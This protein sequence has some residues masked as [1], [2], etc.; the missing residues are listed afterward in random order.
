MGTKRTKPLTAEEREHGVDPSA[1]AET[2][3]DPED[4]GAFR[5]LG[6]R[7]IDDMVDYLETVRERPAWRAIPAEA[8]EA[9]AEP[10][11]R[12]AQGEE[13][14]YRD[15]TRWVLPFPVGNIHPRFWG[16]VQGTGTPL[17]MLAEMLA[18]GMNP[19]ASGFHQSSTYV[20]LRVLDWL[21]ELLGF[22]AEASGLLVTGG[23]VANLV[24]L[25][26][27]RHS[28]AGFDVR[29]AGL[30]SGEPPRTCYAS[31]ETHSSV[32]KAVELLGM[33]TDSLR[34]VATRDDFSVDVDALRSS[35]RLDRSEGRRPLFVV[36]NAGTVN[37]GAVDDLE[38]LADLCVEEGLW[39]HVDGAFGALAWLVPGL[40][41]L[42]R[43]MDRADSIAFDLH[44][45]MYMPYDVGCVL[46]R[47]AED[48]ESTFALTPPYLSRIGGVSQLHT[49]FSDLGLEL[50][51]SFRALK[52]W[53][54][55]KAHGIDKYAALIDQNVSQAQH[56][57]RRVAEGRDLELLPPG[58]LNIVCFRYAPQGAPREALDEL[59]RQILVRLHEEGIAVPSS[60]VL[61]GRFFLRVAITNHRTRC[62]DLD[63]LVREVERLGDEGWARMAGELS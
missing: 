25:A 1:P 55:F 43:G 38:A 42:L 20:E 60:T 37:T 18:A 4:W 59:N 53:M 35:I 21:K 41:P 54:S 5:S 8:R 29:R 45:W 12:Q 3:L 13:A 63:L 11:P 6:H 61:G 39:L 34:Q 23:S 33:G 10:V 52:V 28:R 40:R 46:V 22:P 36:G 51:R 27:A 2:S 19:N 58:P 16:W 14:V 31:T 30:Q 50:S 48:Q 17:G 47:R 7:M 62:S 44:K 32:Q 49:L 9:L 24:G 15:F 57:A 56:L 26:A